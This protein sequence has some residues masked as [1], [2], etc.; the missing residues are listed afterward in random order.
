M[1]RFGYDTLKD[2]DWEEYKR[3]FRTEMSATIWVFQK[4]R[5]VFEKVVKDEAES[6]RIVQGIMLK[7]TDFLRRIIASVAGQ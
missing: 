1:M 4:I 2:G 3:I 6:L 5:D 7:S